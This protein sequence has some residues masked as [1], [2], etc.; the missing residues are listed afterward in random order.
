MR[1]T[2][3]VDLEK[4]AHEILPRD[5]RADG[6]SNPAYNLAVDLKH[7]ESYAKLAGIIVSEM[8]V[9]KF[10]ARFSRKQRLID[11]DMRELIAKMGHWVLRGPLEEREV[12]SYRGIST[13]VAS[14]GG[15]Y[16]ECVEL[17]LE[18]MV[19]S[20]RFIYRVE[21][22][23]GDGELWPVGEYELASRLSYILWGSSPDEELLKLSL[24]HI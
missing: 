20:P 4:E 9:M 21:N 11:D 23:R 17:I 10:A 22:Q 8:D 1:D 7:V 14:A 16:R 15:D 5:Q 6:F 19:Q 13:T 2:L 3:G 12:V 18:A 24:I